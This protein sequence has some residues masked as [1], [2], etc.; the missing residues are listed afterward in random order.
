[1][2]FNQAL[3]RLK[4]YF[5]HYKIEVFSEHAKFDVAVVYKFKDYFWEQNGIKKITKTE[6]KKK[7]IFVIIGLRL[8]IFLAL[9]KFFSSFEGVG[10]KLEIK[11]L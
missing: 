3:K 6:T 9:K 8:S 10:K 11:F 7:N 2:F 4:W 1:M 5:W